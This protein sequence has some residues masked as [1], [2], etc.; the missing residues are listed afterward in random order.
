MTRNT[1]EK[2]G[3]VDHEKVV[4]AYCDPPLV[5]EAGFYV[6]EGE[7]HHSTH[8]SQK[9]TETAVGFMSDDPDKTEFAVPVETEDDVEYEVAH[10]SQFVPTTRVY[11]SP[12]GEGWQYDEPPAGSP[13]TGE[14]SRVV[15]K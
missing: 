5:E 14:P 6:M 11:P 4:V 3:K 15:L 8:M 13:G 9:A 7:L 2:K 1:E 10:E 12:N